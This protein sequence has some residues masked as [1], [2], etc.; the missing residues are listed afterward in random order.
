ME[1]NDSPDHNE[2]CLIEEPISSSK[3]PE[4]LETTELDVVNKCLISTSTTP[5]KVIHTAETPTSVPLMV[6]D[7]STITPTR[8]SSGNPSPTGG[9]YFKYKKLYEDIKVR[10]SHQNELL[11]RVLNENAKL[12][13]EISRIS[14]ANDVPNIVKPDIIQLKRIESDEEIFRLKPKRQN[15]GTKLTELSCEFIDCN[16]K[17]IDLI[18]CNACAKWVCE[19]CNDVPVSKLK[20]IINKCRSVYFL[21]KK[22]DES[23]GSNLQ[24]F[25]NETMKDVGGDIRK[26]IQNVFNQN[27]TKL[28]SKIINSVEKKLVDN[29]QSVNSIAEKIKSQESQTSEVKK[30]YAEILNM[31]KEVRRILQETQNDEKIVINE[32]ERR[33]Q[34][35]IIH[36]AEEFGNNEDEIKKNDEGY[37]NDIL[38]HM[39]LKSKPSEV[40]RLGKLNGNNCRVLKVVMPSKIAKDNVM[41]SLNLL[42]NTEDFFGKISITDDYTATERQLIKDFVNKARDQGRKDTS[43]IFKVRGDPK[44]GL[45]IVSFTKK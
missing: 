27:I 20:P 23:V 35:I 22:C 36:G 40:T 10:Y 31:P 24:V 28:E 5:V 34:N 15:K 8:P 4:S 2:S 38:K 7:V 30:S 39:K 16:E 19:S 33:S 21:C 44:N 37:I 1:T 45:R 14:E 13:L 12:K 26:I 17:G 25:P 18:K 29:L 9:R 11:Q 41:K 3:E 32:Q 42:K 43:R 6:Q